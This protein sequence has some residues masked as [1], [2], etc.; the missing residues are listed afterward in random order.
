MARK[1]GWQLAE[2][3]GSQQPRS[4]QRVLDRSVWDEAA[5]RDELRAYVVDEPGDAAGVLVL[6]E[7][8]FLKQGKKSAGVKRQYSGTAGRIENCQL[9]VFLG[10]AS[11][12][13]RTGLDCT[14]YLPQEWSDD[15]ERR[16]YLIATSAVVEYSVE[17]PGYH[18]R[19]RGHV[20]RLGA[21]RG[22][23]AIRLDPV[24]EGRK[25]ETP[26]W[27]SPPNRSEASPGP[28]S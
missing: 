12:R 3:A 27:P 20:R 25:S 9:G 22:T 7:T 1:N 18:V 15:P 10:Y 24:P 11:S 2:Q 28:S 14:L 21:C 4:I 16:A 26:Q 13:G 8:G 6:D 19:R 5:V 23:R 17:Q